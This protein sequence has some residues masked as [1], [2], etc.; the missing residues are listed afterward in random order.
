[1]QAPTQEAEQTLQGGIKFICTLTHKGAY[2]E[3]RRK[4]IRKE[5]HLGEH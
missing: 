4:K 3:Q 5:K 2:N 1:M